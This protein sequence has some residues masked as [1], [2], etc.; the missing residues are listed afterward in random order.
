MALDI[1]IDRLVGQQLGQVALYYHQVEQVRAVVLLGV[2]VLGLHL[3]RFLLKFDDLLNGGRLVTLSGLEVDSVL[4]R[5]SFEQCFGMGHGHGV[6]VQHQLYSLHLPGRLHV[7]QDAGDVLRELLV[8]KQVDGFGAD[9]FEQVDA[10]VDG[11]EVNVECSGQALAA[12]A[13]VDGGAQHIVLLHR[14][15]TVDTVVA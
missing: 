13:S 5:R 8:L 1:A 3:A 14:R 9:A 12:D 10:A 2:F 4:G 15:Q 7:A 11:A 6:A